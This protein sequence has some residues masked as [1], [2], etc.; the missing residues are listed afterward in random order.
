MHWTRS[1][2]RTATNFCKYQCCN[3]IYFICMS[4]L[5]VRW[6]HLLL[7]TRRP[8]EPEVPGGVPVAPAQLRDEQSARGAPGG[9]LRLRRPWPVRRSR[10]CTGKQGSR[11]LLTAPVLWIRIRRIRY[12][13]GPPGS[14]SISQ[15][16]GSFCYQAKIV[17]KTL[18]P[19][20]L[21]LPDDFLSVLWI[22]IHFF[23]I[24]VRIQSLML[25]TNTDPD[26]NPIR[27]QGLNDQKLKKI[28][29]EI[30]FSFLIKNCN[31]PIPRP[32]SSMSKL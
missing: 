32:P 18:I 15:S 19:T 13:L 7:C 21:L 29:A 12:V 31:L 26:P 4:S 11:P 22:R 16:S 3:E 1:E 2:N 10:L 27:I 24:R 17:R 9:R 6:R 25:E 8:D 30:F 28:T 23:R 14:G 5:P 20:V